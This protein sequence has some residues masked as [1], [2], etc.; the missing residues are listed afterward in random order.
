MRALLALL[1]EIDREGGPQAARDDRLRLLSH[2]EVPDEG[3]PMAT[4]PAT[5][6]APRQALPPAPVVE[7]RPRAAD[8]EQVSVGRL[9]KWGDEHPDPAVQD[10]AAR[11]RMG[12]Y[13]LRARYAADLELETLASEE[14]QLEQRLAELRSR[15][16]QLAPT[17]AKRKAPSYDAAEVR[18]WARQ[19]GVPCPPVGRVPKTVVDAWRDTRTA[20]STG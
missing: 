12:L 3:A 7:V 19:N 2:P 1:D 17:K 8:A 18:A 9:L 20:P 16:E 5:A 6:P 10:Q 13:G 15:R 4:A 14:Q 11:T